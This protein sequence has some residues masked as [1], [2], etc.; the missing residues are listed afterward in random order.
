VTQFPQQLQFQELS[1]VRTEA[2][3]IVPGAMFTV[4]VAGVPSVQEIVWNVVSP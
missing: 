2:C 1:R 3:A 4:S